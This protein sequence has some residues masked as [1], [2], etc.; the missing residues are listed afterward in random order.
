[1]S[2]PIRSGKEALLEAINLPTGSS[3]IEIGCGPGNISNMLTN[4]G[5]KTSGIDPNGDAIKIAAKRM[6]EGTFKQATGEDL[7]FDDQSFHAVLFGNSLHHIPQEHMIASLEEANRLAKSKIV[8][9]EPIAEGPYDTIMKSIDDETII[10]GQAID[11]IATYLNGQSGFER[12]TIEY[13]VNERVESY[14]NMRAEL[15]SIDSSRADLFDRLEGKIKEL[16][17]KYAVKAES[18]YTIA[19]PMRIDVL[20]KN[21]A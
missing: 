11:A 6:P 18:G 9:M 16:F 2:R 4:A 14:E 15:I 21:T 5:Y 7:P 3:V 1:M 20:Q 19:Q 13:T 10:R 12:T 17:D 8:I